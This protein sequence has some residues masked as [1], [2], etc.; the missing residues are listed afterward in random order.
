M[1][2]EAGWSDTSL[3]LQLTAPHRNA[4]GVD[5]EFVWLRQQGKLSE[6][7]YKLNMKQ[8]EMRL[9]RFRLVVRLYRT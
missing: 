9:I 2:Q 6:T 3:S 1:L 4:K 8:E 5:P 7:A